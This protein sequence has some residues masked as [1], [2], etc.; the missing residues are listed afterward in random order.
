VYWNSKVPSNVSVNVSYKQLSARTERELKDNIKLN[1]GETEHEDVNLTE[2]VDFGIN[3]LEL[4]GST[5]CYHVQYIRGSYFTIAPE[6]QTT[7]KYKFEEKF[8]LGC[9]AVVCLIA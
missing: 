9:G 8:L 3:V 4:L 7:V 1:H 6:L 5:A 2:I